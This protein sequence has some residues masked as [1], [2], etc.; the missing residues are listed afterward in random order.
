[1]LLV[2]KAGT[3]IFVVNGDKLDLPVFLKGKKPVGVLQPLCSI[4]MAEAFEKIPLLR[5][6]SAQLGPSIE[7]PQ[8]EVENLDPLVRT[9]LRDGSLGLAVLGLLL[10]VLLVHTFFWL[11]FCLAAFLLPSLCPLFPVKVLA[12][13][14]VWTCRTDSHTTGCLFLI[15]RLWNP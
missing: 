4:F 6:K 10:L 12:A 1:M 8:Q 15:A 3:S 2:L 11:L 5:Q 7:L 13:S 9:Q 14:P